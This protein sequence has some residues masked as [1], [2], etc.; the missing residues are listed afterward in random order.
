MADKTILDRKMMLLRVD[1]EIDILR[2]VIEAFFETYPDQLGEIRALLLKE[3]GE[4]ASRVAHSLKGSIQTFFKGPLATLVFNTES[5]ARDGNHADALESLNALEL[6]FQACKTLL[7]D[8]R[9]YLE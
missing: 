4:Q 7:E 1:G 8:L 6:E 9:D 3:E 5:A 2:Q